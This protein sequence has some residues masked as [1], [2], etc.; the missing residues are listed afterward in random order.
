[1]LC[2]RPICKNYII[3]AFNTNF[4]PTTL[5]LY[6][7]NILKFNI[8]NFFFT[9]VK[10]DDDDEYED[11]G[12]VAQNQSVI[13]H[14][15]LHLICISDSSNT[16]LIAGV[17]VGSLVVLIL[18]VLVLVYFLVIRRKKEEPCKWFDNDVASI[19]HD[20]DNRY[21]EYLNQY[22]LWKVSSGTDWLIVC[23]LSNIWNM[24][25]QTASLGSV[26]MHFSQRKM[27]TPS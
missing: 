23:C 17:V 8:F 16:P 19:Q 25:N 27:L 22:L 26:P 14:L 4:T 18:I 20:K 1:M 21:C 6:W 9:F 24:K 13:S 7:T 2:R 3:I 11:D 15:M 12:L 10:N 5:K